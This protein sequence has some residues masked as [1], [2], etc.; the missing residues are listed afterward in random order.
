MTTSTARPLLGCIADDFTGATDLANMLVRGGMRTVQSIGIPGAEVAE[1]LDAELMELS[2]PSGLGPLVAEHG[3][4]IEK[5]QGCLLRETLGNEC[6]GHT[7][8][9]FRAQGHTFPTLGFEGVHFF[10]DD[11]CGVA[12]RAREHVRRL[13]NRRG[14]F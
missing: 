12:Q 3:A 2:E 1:R 14:D 6:T 5:L 10:G 8:R 13:E 9:S 4:V 11:I 7:R